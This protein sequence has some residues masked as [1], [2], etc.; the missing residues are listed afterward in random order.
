MILYDPTIPASLLEFGIQIPIRNSRTTQTY[1]ALRRHPRIG[2]RLTQLH[3]ARITEK[4]DRQDL[5]RAHAPDY[6]A[7]LYSDQLEQ[8]ITAT[9]E[10]LDAQGQYNRYDPDK[11][12]LPLT[13]LFERILHKAAGT[14]QC[15]RLA[16]AHGFCFYFSGGMHHAHFDHGSGFCLINDL[17][18]AA[19]KL[20]AE[21]KLQRVWIIDVDAHKGDGTAAITNHDPTITTLSEHMAGGWPLD[22]P[23]TL[24]DG[25]PNPA[26]TP[27][28]I[29]IPIESGEEGLYLDRLEQGLKQLA[30]GTPADLAIVELGADPYE[31]DELPSTAKLKLSLEQLLLRD[32][33]IYNFLK[34]QGIP[35]A[36][37]MAGGYGET[38]WKVFAQFLTWALESK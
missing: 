18:I 8:V 28:D 16:L 3:H 13:D 30:H 11:A 7:R 29:D 38:V 14:V 25:K 35:A 32:Q 1:E 22:A 4:L 19:R 24:A 21:K 2:K 34:T 20:Q 9:Y 5:Q 6:V 36:F 37:V 10:L 26:F 17:V 27:S 15:S 33:L 31:E 12:Q 23:T